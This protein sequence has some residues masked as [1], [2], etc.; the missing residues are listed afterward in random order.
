MLNCSLEKRLVEQQIL[1]FQA[2]HVQKYGPRE[3]TYANDYWKHPQRQALLTT[4]RLFYSN[5]IM[6]KIDLATW[7]LNEMWGSKAMDNAAI[8]ANVPASVINGKG[9]HALSI[10][11]LRCATN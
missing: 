4:Q 11:M 5:M 1:K 6:H 8:E 2:Y 7:G 10:E 9:L 3:T